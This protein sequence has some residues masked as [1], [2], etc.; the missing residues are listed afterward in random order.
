MCF[1]TAAT[2]D[3]RGA[4]P[5]GFTE[6][7]V[8]DRDDRRADERR[9]SAGT[10]GRDGDPRYSRKAF[11]LLL[12][13]A[14]ASLAGLA[15]LGRRLSSSPS[16]PT[17]PTRLT[18]APSSASPAVARKDFPVRTAESVSDEPAPLEHWVIDVDGLVER[19]LKIDY[20]AWTALPRTDETVNFHCVEGWSV[21][22]VKWS[23][24]RPG[25]LLAL[26]RPLPQATHVDFH[27]AGGTYFDS[28]TMEQIDDPMTLLADSLDGVVLPR[29]HGGPVRLV[30]PAQFGYK[31]VKFV[32]R[33]EVVDESHCGYWESR[34]YPVDAPIS[35]WNRDG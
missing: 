35:G 26:A 17:P 16:P 20:A 25:D 4:V 29:E 5:P 9:E 32:Q 31:S 23:G 30:V 13:G 10:P 24:V 11:L 12:G 6:V 33:L 14:A 19:P 21:H 2:N 7:K 22:D 28:L 34:G 3:R 18:G 27:A 15:E 1:L 8:D